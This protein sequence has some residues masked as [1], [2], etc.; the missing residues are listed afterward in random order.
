MHCA[1]N[2]HWTRQGRVD[3]CNIHYVEYKL[4]HIIDYANTN[5]KMIHDDWQNLNI[6]KYVNMFG[7]FISKKSVFNIKA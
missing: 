2:L 5:I 3:V 6:E 7:F 4:K 1:L